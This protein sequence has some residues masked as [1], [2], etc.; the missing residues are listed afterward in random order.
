[1]SVGS[2]IAIAGI[3][4]AVAALAWADTLLGIV[5]VFGAYAATCAIMGRDG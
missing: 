3:W 1:M 2:G 4:A 5:G